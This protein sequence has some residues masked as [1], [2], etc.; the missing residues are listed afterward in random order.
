[1]TMKENEEARDEK[2]F[3]RKARILLGCIHLAEGL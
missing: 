2:A 3:K 1:M